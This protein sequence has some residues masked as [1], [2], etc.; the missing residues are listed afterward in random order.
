VGTYKLDDGPG[1]FGFSTK[2]PSKVLK[3]GDEVLLSHFGSFKEIRMN[4]TQIGEKDLTAKASQ[5]HLVN[6]NKGDHVVFRNDPQGSDY[7]VSACVV[8]VESIDPL[9]FKAEVNIIEKMKGLK[10]A[11]RFYTSLPADV[12]IVGITENVP[13]VVKKVSLEAIKISC[14]EDIMTEDIIDIVVKMDEKRKFQFRGRV[15]KKVKINDKFDYGIDVYDMTDG[16]KQ[17]WFRYISEL[18]IS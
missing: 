16:N 11:K 10:K 17:T 7:V 18:E 15:V 1:I 13:V 9:E 4:I 6:I 2:N 14:K 3:V 12:K 8:S 5:N